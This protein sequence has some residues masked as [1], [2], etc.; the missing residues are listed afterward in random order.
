[1]LLPLLLLFLGQTAARPQLASTAVVMPRGGDAVVQLA[2]DGAQLPTTTAIDL[3]VDGE[4]RTT[5]LLFGNVGH[6]TYGAL[7]TGLS[8]GR[9]T[10]TAQP[11]PYWP[12]PATAAAPSLSVFPAPD[13]VVL[14]HAP[15]L[16]LRSDT[17]GVATDLPLMM[18]AEDLRVNGTGLLRYSV[19]FSNE[20]GGTATA[21]LLA[22]WGRTTD[23]EMAYE[24]DW[25][26]GQVIA[27][28]YQG[29][30]HHTP[31]YG[32]TREGAHPPLVVATL[33]N[34]FLDRG[35]TAVRVA[36][37]PTLVDL[38]SAT[39]ESVMDREPWIYKRMADEL[40]EERKAAVSGDIREYLF[41]DARLTL[42]DAAVAAT[43]RGE[44]G[45]WRSSDRGLK[46]LTV[47]RS[48]WVRIAIPGSKRAVE[49]GFVCVPTKLS[50][51]RCQVEIGKVFSL[52]DDYTPGVQRGT[53]ALDVQSGQ[54]RTAPL[55]RQ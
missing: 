28:R 38:Q 23:I 1:M 18:Y 52:N 37:V 40:R 9:H 50:V 33:N 24:E 54:M 25:R 19:I 21:A 47:E 46:D 39:R 2:A 44:D 29:P 41:V 11:S 5:V 20:D 13:S 12:W 31:D 51:G 45:I 42:T 30:D 14:A 35:R 15:V 3:L 6:P 8:A 7:L 32:A 49:V 36:L 4:I 17:I 22:R 53:G 26:D 34:V 27:S 43:A 55:S 10:V 48:G 16:W